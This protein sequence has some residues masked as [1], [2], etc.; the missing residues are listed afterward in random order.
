MK[1][2]ALENKIIN[3]HECQNKILLD[4]WLKAFTCLCEYNFS[5]SSLILEKARC[6]PQS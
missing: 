1:C 6:N 3:G 5:I 2:K 4:I